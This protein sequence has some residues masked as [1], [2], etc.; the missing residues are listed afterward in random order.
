MIMDMLVRRMRDRDNC[1]FNKRKGWLL[2][3][4]KE[5]S[6]IIDDWRGERMTVRVVSC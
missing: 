2:I 5:E 1:C 6:R 3:V 4:K